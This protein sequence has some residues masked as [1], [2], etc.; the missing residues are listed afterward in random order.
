MAGSGELFT[1][2]WQQKRWAH[3]PYLPKE[4]SVDGRP[5]PIGNSNHVI[6]SG[7]QVWLGRQIEAHPQN[8]AWQELQS[9]H[10]SSSASPCD[11]DELNG[12]R[13]LRSRQRITLTTIVEL[14]PGN[15]RDL[16]VSFLTIL[17]TSVT[18]MAALTTLLVPSMTIQVTSIPLLITSAALCYSLLLSMISEL[19]FRHSIC[20]MYS[21]GRYSQTSCMCK[22]SNLPDFDG[23]LSC[24]RIAG[25]L[26]CAILLCPIQP[27][28]T[29]VCYAFDRGP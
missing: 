10:R 4:L 6:M 15:F 19:V 5:S 23:L 26:H 25:Q 29:G 21:V 17:I 18:L 13:V 3:H 16:T 12:P 14:P 20:N 24:C 22:A 1:A 7:V 8:P 27:C 11:R 9:S 28:G 2:C